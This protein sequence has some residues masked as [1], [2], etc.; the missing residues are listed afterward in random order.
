MSVNTAQPVQHSRLKAYLAGLVGAWIAA[1]TFLVGSETTVRFA[2][3]EL[4]WFRITSSFVVI[5]LVHRWRSPGK[6]IE[7]ADI[8]SLVLMGLSGITANQL[9]F[10][11]GI[12]L[13]PPIDGALIYAF[14]PLT[15]MVIARFTLGEALTWSKV[16]GIALALA[17]VFMVLLERGLEVGAGHWRGDGILVLAM[18]A[19]ACYTLIGKR[20]MGIYG[21]M[22]VNTYAFGVGA[23][24]V[25]P[26]SWHVLHDFDWA[27]PGL[28]GWLGLVYL[29][30]G[31]SVISFTLWTYALKALEASQVAIFTNL[32]P[33]MTVVLVWWFLGEAPT[34]AILGGIVLVIIGVML[35]QRQ[36]K[37]N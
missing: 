16:L 13:A 11:H 30:V 15:V 19:W 26:L 32:Q 25:L 35:S 24:S 6:P 28:A 22:T 33:A 12:H 10:L 5:W 36:Q 34:V 9:L 4:G 14:L 3:L 18:L 27:G 17:G 31:T 20:L 1:G 23:L 2:P 7:R 29:S 37:P 8:P 21:A